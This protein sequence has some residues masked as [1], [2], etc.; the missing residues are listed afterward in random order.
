MR[1][2]I[3]VI[4]LSDWFYYCALTLITILVGQIPVILH[5]FHTP[6]GYYYPYLDTVAAVGDYYYHA[7]IRFGMGSD[8]LVKIPYVIA[9]H[10]ASL[11]QIIFVWLGKFALVIRAGPAEIFAISRVIGGMIYAVSVILFMKLILEKK[12]ARLAFLFFLFA[13]P[14]SFTSINK[15]FNQD[16]GRWIWFF[17]EA[18]RR[19]SIMPPHYTIGRG[20]AIFSISF[21]IIYLN[22]KRLLFLTLMFASAVLGGIIYPPPVFI[23]L[24]SV[25]LTMITY[26]ISIRISN[27]KNL[28]TKSV[29][30]FILF[31][32]GCLLP[33]I[34]LKMELAKGYPWNMWNKVEL[35]WNA[36]TMHFER[37]YLEMLGLLILLVPFSIIKLFD[38][39]I[40][41]WK[42]YFLFYWAISAFLL[43]PFANLL[44]VGK[45]RFSEGAQIVP[46]SILASWGFLTISKYSVKYFNS[47]VTCILQVMIISLVVIN[48]IIFTIL[49]VRNYT[50]SLWGYWTNVYFRPVELSALKYLRENTGSGAVVL[51]S[52]N[53]SSYLPSF[54]SINTIIGLSDSYEKFTDFE[55]EKQRIDSILAGTA[56]ENEVKEYVQTRKVNYIYFEKYTFGKKILYPQLLVPLYEN[57]GFTIFQVR[58]D[59]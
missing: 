38:R 18:A 53:V 51:A 40:R 21:Y 42:I 8:W 27:W 48:F 46:I 28:A 26:L 41:D 13:Q 2:K 44:Q 6:K 58:K 4:V 15:L 49:T 24:L 3:K 54:A 32:L 55:Y 43:F 56:S 57:D 35:G 45:F 47:K 33:L 30:G 14:F 20:L 25:S 12:Q 39:K 19:I 29:I 34:I 23:L 10:Q 5:I 17:D 50:L 1:K 31:I 7:L 11:I 9:D 52:G 22:N 59:V 16:F 36:S 37:D